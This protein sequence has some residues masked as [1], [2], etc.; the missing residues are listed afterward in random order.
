VSAAG[1]APLPDRVVALQS[2]PQPTTIQQL[3]AF[4]GLF[5]FYRR[6]VPAAAAIVRPL[7][8][9]LRSGRKGSA[10]VVWTPPLLQAFS[11]AKAALAAATLLDH[12]ALGADISVV[13]NASSTHV[14]AVLQQRRSGGAWRPLGFFSRKLNT[15]ESHYSAFDR[16]LLAVYSSLLHFRH[17][18]E[19]RRF[20]VF[21]DH[22]QLV[23]A[24]TPVSEAEIGQAAAAAVSHCG[25]DRRHKAHCQAHQC[26]GRHVVKAAAAS[27]MQCSSGASR[28]GLRWVFRGPR[29]RG[30]RRGREFCGQCSSSILR[31]SGERQPTGPDQCCNHQ[32]ISGRRSSG[33]ALSTG[34]RSSG[35]MLNGTFGHQSDS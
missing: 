5:N 2:F 11:A 12:P 35:A 9:A 34:H 15:A 33:A 25:A 27:V 29:K 14:G 17:M 24:L 31:R 1:V 10:P 7:T 23:G 18:L 16:E 32:G 8:D 6:F 22:K 4:L 28:G 13:T 30:R 19:G 26:G 21:T 20:T 3:Q